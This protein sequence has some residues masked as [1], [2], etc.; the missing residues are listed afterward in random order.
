MQSVSSRELK[1][2]GRVSSPEYAV[3]LRAATRLSRRAAT[4]FSCLDR[5][6][7]IDRFYRLDRPLRRAR[8]PHR[9]DERAG[10]GPSVGL[11]RH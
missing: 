5:F 8:P 1:L 2:L 3:L 7:R 6:C 10:G 11:P 4:S 9:P